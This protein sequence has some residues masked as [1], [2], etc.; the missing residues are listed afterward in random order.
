MQ[1]V[2]TTLQGMAASLPSAAI[3]LVLG[4]LTCFF[5]YRLR[6]VFV[7]VTGLLLGF[8]GGYAV[9]STL[10]TGGNALIAGAVT[11]II[12]M[13]LCVLLYN[14]GIFILCG[15]S[16]A[17]ICYALMSELALDWRANLLVTLVI[18]VAAGILS[19]K[20]VRPVLIVSTAFSGGSSLVT[21]A[22][23]LAATTGLGALPYATLI[24]LAVGIVGV[25][26]QFKN[27]K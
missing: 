2:S 17:V 14:V 13:L 23:G 22:A 16:G 1:E 20:F 27:S 7:G 6:K 21:A 9:A 10:T 4:V 12:L 15:C 18:F 5:G 24:A 3:T 25:L 11:G 8:L 19:L 26:V